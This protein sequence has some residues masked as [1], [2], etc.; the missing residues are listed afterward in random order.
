[1]SHSYLIQGN[2]VFAAHTQ[3]NYRCIAFLNGKRQTTGWVRQE[4]L[5]PI[6][7]TAANTTWQGTWIRQAGDA[8]IVIRKQGSGLYATASATLA[9]SRDNV[10]TGGAKGKLDLQRSVASFGEEGDRATVCRVNVRLL[11]DVLLADDGATDDANSSCG[12]MG[13]SLNGIYRRAAK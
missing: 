8:E 4:A 13:V 9:V 1:M 2:R 7:L 12:G 6:P 3:G 10:R 11:D 5:I